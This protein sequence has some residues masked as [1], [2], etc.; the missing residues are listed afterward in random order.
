MEWKNGPDNRLRQEKCFIEKLERKTATIETISKWTNHFLNSIV[1]IF[2]LT[3]LNRLF[4]CQMHCFLAMNE[5]SRWANTFSSAEFSLEQVSNCLQPFSNS[6]YV[7]TVYNNRIQLVSK[8]RLTWTWKPTLVFAVYV[9]T[10]CRYWEPKLLR[11]YCLHRLW[12]HLVFFIELSGGWSVKAS[13]EE[14]NSVS[15]VHLKPLN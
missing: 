1:A 6:N 12:F 13:V 15:N 3:N 2:G 7:K 4:R 9:S 8:R 10:E 5:N 14:G 11:S